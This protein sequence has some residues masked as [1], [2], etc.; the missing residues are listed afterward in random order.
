MH[1]AGVNLRRAVSIIEVVVALVVFCVGAL[2][3][4]AALTVSVRAQRLAAA[5]RD[6]T[7]ALI[8]QA[9]ALASLPCTA[10]AGG[11]QAIGAVTVRWTVADRKS[12]RL[13]SSHSA[14]SR[15]PSSA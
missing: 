1:H 15:M 14:K 7:A 9:D 12:T 13:N 11:Q 10:L 4:A 8:L 6:A 2:G 3:S 5:R